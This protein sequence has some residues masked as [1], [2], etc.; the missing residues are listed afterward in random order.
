[1]GIKGGLE[2][3][4]MRQFVWKCLSFLSP[5]L[6]M[7]CL[8]ELYI[9]YAPNTFYF[10][11]RYLK[12]HLNDAELVVFG[13]SHN[14]NAIN[15]YDFDL[16]LVNLAYGGQDYQ[17]DSLL[18]FKYVPQMP[19]IKAV[20][21]EFD[22]L[23]INNR[24]GSNYFRLPWYYRHYGASL[25]SLNLMNKLSLYFSSPTFFNNYLKLELDPSGY[26]YILS[27]NGFI[28]NDFPGEMFDC[29]YNVEVLETVSNKELQKLQELETFHNLNRNFRTLD[30]MIA[31]CL[32][33]NIRVVL[34]APPSYL[35]MKALEKNVKSGLMHRYRDSLM[36]ASERILYSNHQN[37][38]KFTVKDFKNL[39]HLN[40]D[41][42]TK[43]SLLLNHEIKGILH[44]E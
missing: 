8:V 18:F 24:V 36:N 4:G 10:K 39:T 40:S 19:N 37:N 29:N 17:L 21:F 22:Y 32:N 9:S 12:D 31:Y 15:P 42:A 26:R 44:N 1:M 27:N 2:N 30:R 28:V 5:F 14:Q 25:N 3:F 7:F 11:S 38:P 20:V 33:N 35:K 34:V 13:S 16:Q 43:Y 41:G 6:G 23:T